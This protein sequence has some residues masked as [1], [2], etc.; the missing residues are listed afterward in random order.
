M[1]ITKRMTIRENEVRKSDLHVFKLRERAKIAAPAPVREEEPIRQEV[2]TK[3]KK[4]KKQ[5]I[6]AK[7]AEKRDRQRF[8]ASERR[9]REEQN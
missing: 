5:R 1:L 6:E 4:N 7:K 2:K 9:A 8:G 3:I